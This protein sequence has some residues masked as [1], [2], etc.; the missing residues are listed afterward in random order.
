MFDKVND[1]INIDFFNVKGFFVGIIILGS[2]FIVV[3][4]SVLFV[5]DVDFF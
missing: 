3:G 4:Y 5:V 1:L 2:G